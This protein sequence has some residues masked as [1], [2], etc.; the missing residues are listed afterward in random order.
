MRELE[1]LLE[2]IFVLETDDQILVKHIPPRI[3]REL[4][5]GASLTHSNSLTEIIGVNKSFQDATSEFQVKIIQNALSL[6]NGKLSQAADLLGLSR[7]AL[8]H[9]MNKLHMR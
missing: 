6:K 2:R 4:E 3:M 7:H 9:Q 1:N 8:R 5:S